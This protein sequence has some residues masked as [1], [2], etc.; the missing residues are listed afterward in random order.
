MKGEKGC[1]GQ[2]D[3]LRYNMGR[4][5]RVPDLII[6]TSISSNSY[7]GKKCVSPWGFNKVEL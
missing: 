2:L 3:S 4:V 6:C 5:T 7:Y 1:T